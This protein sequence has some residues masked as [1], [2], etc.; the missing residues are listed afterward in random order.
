MIDAGTLAMFQ[1]RKVVV[2][3][4]PLDM[5]QLDIMT[6]FCQFGSIEGVVMK[7]NTKYIN[8]NYAFVK[9]SEQASVENA[10]QIDNHLIKMRAV[11]VRRVFKTQVPS[12]PFPCMEPTAAPLVHSVW[13]DNSSVW[14]S[15]LFRLVSAS[16]NQ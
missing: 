1:P 13:D 8:Q 9:F 3:G 4:L 6:Y 12:R 11:R 7:A 14:E 16:W 15:P 10:L 2:L 5:T